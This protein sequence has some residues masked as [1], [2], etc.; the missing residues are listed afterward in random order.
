MLRAPGS[1]V[2][3]LL[4]L[5]VYTRRVPTNCPHTYASHV[6]PSRSAEAALTIQTNPKHYMLRV[7]NPYFSILLLLYYL[8]LLTVYGAPLQSVVVSSTSKQGPFGSESFEN[9]PSS[10][11]ASSSTS[12]VKSSF[13][14]AFQHGPGSTNTNPYEPISLSSLSKRD[15][16][17][18]VLTRPS[19]THPL[20]TLS[21]PT[22]QDYRRSRGLGNLERTTLSV[23]ST[24]SKMSQLS[25]VSAISDLPN[26]QRATNPSIYI[27]YRPAA[28]PPIPLAGT[29]EEDTRSHTDNLTSA[30]LRSS[31][32]TSTHSKF[33][34]ASTLQGNE[35]PWEL[36]AEPEPSILQTK[37]P[38]PRYDPR[39]QPA[40]LE[41]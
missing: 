37:S 20:Q 28:P 5:N 23:S 32:V 41:L 3:I 21:T 4:K 26:P 17:E 35:T 12:A 2:A 8:T 31:S 22:G 9:N 6:N 16:P 40:N 39:L 36:S 1:P 33:S 19:P 38:Y 15:D 14:H 30:P 18:R 27:P 24:S 29:F 13:Q 34:D 25:A 7:P 11:D 10:D